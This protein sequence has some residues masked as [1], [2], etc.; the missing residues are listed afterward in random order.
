[1]SEETVYNS[2]HEL[3]EA[4]HTGDIDPAD[5]YVY[6][7]K[8]YAYALLENPEAFIDGYENAISTRYGAEDEEKQVLVDVSK[9]SPEEILVDLLDA[10]GMDA[11]YRHR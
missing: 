1:M 2:F 6:V 4:V 10:A 5:V 8:T 11:T 3:L 9:T 7:D